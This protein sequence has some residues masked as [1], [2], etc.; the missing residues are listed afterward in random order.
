[1]LLLAFAGSG[2]SQNRKI[3]MQDKTS[4]SSI[5]AR[6]WLPGKSENKI[7]GVLAPD[8]DGRWLLQL[9]GSFEMSGEES[10]VPPGNFATTLLTMPDDYSSLIGEDPEGVYITLLVS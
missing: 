7:H 10:A 9:E 4:V 8:S 6:W 1:L 5:S 3:Q 2:V